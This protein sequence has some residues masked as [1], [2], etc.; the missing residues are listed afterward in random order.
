MGGASSPVIADLTLSVLEYRYMIANPNPDRFLGTCRYIDDLADVNTD[1]FMLIALDIYPAEILLS[2]TNTNDS[3]AN[4]LDVSIQIINDQYSRRF[5]FS[6][7][8]KTRD[9]NFSVLKYTHRDSNVS[10]NIGY[11]IFS[12]QIFR[13]FQIN[14]NKK[15][16]LIE[17]NKIGSI[18]LKNGYKKS[19]LLKTYFKIF[20]KHEKIALKFGM[21]SKTSIALSAVKMF[22]NL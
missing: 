6:L 2:K 3:C 11:N 19:E 13:S 18:L 15:E 20:E 10:A 1:D 12:S 4:F 14:S 5:K 8:D 16:F 7:Y 21:F 17:A 22:K 9:F